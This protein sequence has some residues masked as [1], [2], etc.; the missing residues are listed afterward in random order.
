MSDP[1]GTALSSADELFVDWDAVSSSEWGC[2]SLLSFLSF[3]DVE[4]LLGWAHH[5]M[6]TKH[7]PTDINADNPLPTLPS[8]LGVPPSLLDFFADQASWDAEKRRLWESMPFSA[9]I[10]TATAL[11]EA[12]VATFLPLARRY[13][14]LCR[15]Q[16]EDPMTADTGAQIFGGEAT[17]SME[18]WVVPPEQALL[19]LIQDEAAAT[20][21]PASTS[22]MGTLE[23]I[24]QW[25][26]APILLETFAEVPEQ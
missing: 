5:K 2:T 1:F 3:P 21:S 22:S 24:Q 8:G 20:S 17:A 23:C 11:E 12:M 9:R 13:V 15:W 14:E 26:D 19:R 16:E 4:H 10:A 25:H 6:D 7:N 18:R